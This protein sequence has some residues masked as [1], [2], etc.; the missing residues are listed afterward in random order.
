MT[1]AAAAADVAEL[2]VKTG[3]IMRNIVSHCC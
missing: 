2:E 1:I 3:I